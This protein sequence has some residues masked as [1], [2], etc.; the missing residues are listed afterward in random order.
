MRLSSNRAKNF[1]SLMATFLISGYFVVH[2]LGVGGDKGYLSIGALNDDI[3][4]ANIKLAE[5]RQHR[6][7]LQH[8]VSLVSEDQVDA[9][10][11]GEIARAEGG[12]YA[13]DEL[14]I[15]LN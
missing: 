14:I 5:L 3:A 6:E 2:G 1:I 12:L 7:W 13:A 9:D 8:R 10:F 11:L 15:D 4:S